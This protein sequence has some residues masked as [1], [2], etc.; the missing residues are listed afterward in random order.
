[1]LNSYLTDTAALL[2]DTNNLFYSPAFLTNFINRA[3]RWIAIQTLQPRVLVT[4]LSTVANQE[5][6]A[7][8]LANAAVAAVPG[9]ASPYGVWGVAV[10]EANYFIALGRMDF[11]SFQAYRRILNNTA[12][13]YPDKFST[14]NRGAAQVIYLSL[15]PAAVYAMIW[16]VACIPVNLVDD[17]TIEA[18]PE[19][20]TEIIPFKAASYACETQQRWA[21]AEEFDDDVE[22]MMA[23][24]SVASVPFLSPDWYPEK[25]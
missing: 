20:W 10:A 2:N 11:P 13:N 7:I 8:T 1:L 25:R 12:Q 3:R 18:L 23:E 6:Y 16:D 9:V 14:Y 5:A 22:R 15:V 24:A 21:D 19:P 4:T 17:T